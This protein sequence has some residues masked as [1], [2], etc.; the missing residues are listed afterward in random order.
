MEH[1]DLLEILEDRH[2]HGSTIVTSRLPV[3][4]WHETIGDPTLAD[5]ILDRL[6]RNAHRLP[7]S[8][9]SMHKRASTPN[10]LD[11]SD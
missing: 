4:N 7:L 2:G 6:A 1:R 5:A 9:D 11:A 3:E 8:G 10:A